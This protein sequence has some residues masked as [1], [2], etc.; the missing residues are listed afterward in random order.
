SKMTTFRVL[1]CLAVVCI[2][3]SLAQRGFRFPSKLEL[4]VA[5]DNPDTVGKALQ[6]IE[7]FECKLPYG[8]LL[9]RAGPELITLGRCPRRMCTQEQ[10][11]TARWLIVEIQKRYP[12]R[13]Y[14]TLNRLAANRA[15]I[16]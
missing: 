3:P 10:E 16:G 2:V 1:L 6:C 7:G 13:F 11:R 15:A 5:L 4:Q 8:N 12:K 14:A 9:R